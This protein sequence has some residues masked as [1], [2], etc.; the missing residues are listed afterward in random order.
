MS[1]DSDA[2][3]MDRLMDDIDAVTPPSDGRYAH[4]LTRDEQIERRAAS[5]R[6]YIERGLAD[7]AKGAADALAHYARK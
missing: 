1:T 4:E 6:W 7:H 2:A 5:V 3:L